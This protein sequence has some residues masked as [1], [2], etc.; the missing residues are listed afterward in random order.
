MAAGLLQAA[1]GRS[2]C[3]EEGVGDS[4]NANA[5][6][7]GCISIFAP[8]RSYRAH[9]FSA[10]SSIIG[11]TLSTA[12]S[13]RGHQPG[14]PVMGHANGP[15]APPSHRVWI[16]TRIDRFATEKLGRLRNAY[17]EGY[18]IPTC[19]VRLEY[20]WVRML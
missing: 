18:V 11:S 7:Y 5:A 4:R 8:V 6:A 15:F 14:Y 2:V 20:K 12:T 16:R 17:R 10:G 19:A 3:S 9:I 13:R 1:H